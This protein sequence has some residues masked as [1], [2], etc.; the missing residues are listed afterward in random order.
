MPQPHSATNDARTHVNQRARILPMP[1][2]TWLG[3]TFAVTF[4]RRA[5]MPTGFTHFLKLCCSCQSW[6]G[7][8][9]VVNDE[10]HVLREVRSRI[11]SPRGFIFPVARPLRK[12]GARAWCEVAA[13]LLEHRAGLD[14][15]TRSADLPSA[16]ASFR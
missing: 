1:F 12:C 2:L 14:S 4:G 6:D 15:A 7:E 3:K 11:S 13:T 16:H 8:V 10:V 9:P 5:Q